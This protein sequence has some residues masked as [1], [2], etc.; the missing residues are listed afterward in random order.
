M[1]QHISLIPQDR[2]IFR[3]RQIIRLATHQGTCVSRTIKTGANVAFARFPEF[4]TRLLWN[5]LHMVGLHST[6]PSTFPF[7]PRQKN[8]SAAANNQTCHTPGSMWLSKHGNRRDVAFARFPEF[9]TRLLWNCLHMAGLHSMCPGTFSFSP[10]T[11]NNSVTANNQT[12][13]APGSMW[14][15]NHENRH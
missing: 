12:C 10:K 4:Y 14:L 5:C 2:N 15:S 8:N 6:C 3:Q 11:E 13:H 1:P 9:Y 7:S